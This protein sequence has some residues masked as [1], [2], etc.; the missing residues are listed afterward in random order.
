[1][2][3]K[4]SYLPGIC[5]E[6]AVPAPILLVQ[7]SLDRIFSTILPSH[8]QNC[9]TYGHFWVHIRT[10]RPKIPHTTC[11]QRPTE[12]FEKQ[13]FCQ[14]FRSGTA[15]F[16]PNSKWTATFGTN[17]RILHQKLPPCTSFWIFSEHELQFYDPQKNCIFSEKSALL[18]SKMAGV[19]N[20]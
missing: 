19:Y 4:N 14:I 10:L 20:Y 11:F 5:P 7:P 17:I 16:R 13:D 18:S 3:L 12:I 9:G 15:T 6:A 8:G 2:T 1:M